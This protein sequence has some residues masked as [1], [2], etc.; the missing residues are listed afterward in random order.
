LRPSLD[1]GHIPCERISL[2]RTLSGGNRSPQ[3]R[4]QYQDWKPDRH[5]FHSSI[6]LRKS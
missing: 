4:Q 5:P 6:I 1:F 3:P 2:R